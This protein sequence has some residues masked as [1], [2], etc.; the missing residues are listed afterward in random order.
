ME[1]AR[2][3]LRFTPNGWSSGTLITGLA[4]DGMR[5]LRGVL[6][7]PFDL[8]VTHTLV[9]RAGRRTALPPGAQVAGDAR[10]PAPEGSVRLV[11]GAAVTQ[12]GKCV[13]RLSALWCDRATGRI[14][15][16]LVRPTG[17]LLRR[18]AERV[19]SAEEVS[20]LTGEGLVLTTGTAPI[21]AL[22]PYRADSEIEADLRLAL[23]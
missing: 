14:T 21:Q 13:G 16:V 22:T 4:A 18:P 3:E 23:A 2:L 10:T 9:K 17:S 6:V 20:E 8:V 7:R 19:L 12:G 15:H 1:Y 11:K 5:G